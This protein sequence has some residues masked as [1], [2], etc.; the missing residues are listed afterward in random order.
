MIIPA[1]QRPWFPLAAEECIP[2]GPYAAM[3]FK[4]MYAS[5]EAEHLQLNYSLMGFLHIDPNAVPRKYLRYTAFLAKAMQAEAMIRDGVEQPAASEPSFHCWH[6]TYGFNVH[7]TLAHQESVP[8]SEPESSRSM[9]EMGWGLVSTV[10]QMDSTVRPS[11]GLVTA[12][13]TSKFPAEP[14]C[15]SC[16]SPCKR[17]FAWRCHG[18]VGKGLQLAPR[19]ITYA[20]DD[21]GNGW[22][23]YCYNCRPPP[24]WYQ[25][26]S[27]D[28]WDMWLSGQ[29]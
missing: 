6:E 24:N 10:R 5:Q 28:A 22:L 13:A 14:S 3:T 1:D 15:A 12:T 19:P 8:E 11:V 2:E 20:Y 9:E 18:I 29:P 7:G 21:L 16:E 27:G 26:A 23:A 4:E 17:H 25:D